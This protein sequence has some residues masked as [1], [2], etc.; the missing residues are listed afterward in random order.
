LQYFHPDWQQIPNWPV[1]LLTSRQ[2]PP[3]PPQHRYP[4]TKLCFPQQTG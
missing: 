2:A 1:Q 3:E 4:L